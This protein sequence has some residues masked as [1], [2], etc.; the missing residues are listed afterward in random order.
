MFDHNKVS[1]L[2]GMEIKPRKLLYYCTYVFHITPCEGSIHGEWVVY[3]I[4]GGTKVH[5]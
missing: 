4:I 2:D 5:S 3:L 1:G